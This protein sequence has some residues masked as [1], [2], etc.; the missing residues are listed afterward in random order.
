MNPHQ[1]PAQVFT[2]RDKLPLTILNGSPG[3]INLCDALNAW[4][5]VRELKQAVGLPAAAS[6]KHV[7]PAGAAVG[8]P[9]DETEVGYCQCI[10][11]SLKLAVWRL[12]K[13]KITQDHRLQINKGNKQDISVIVA[14][15]V[16]RFG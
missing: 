11:A 15:G 14:Q 5:L 16:A 8:L 2:T 12:V 1:K 7:S 13:R 6:F 4:Q 3:Y 10:L 9:L